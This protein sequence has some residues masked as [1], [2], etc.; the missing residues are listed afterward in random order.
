M[1][2]DWQVR[3]QV[4]VASTGAFFPPGTPR[5]EIETAKRDL[6]EAGMVVEERNE[7]PDGQPDPAWVHVTGERPA[8]SSSGAWAPSRLVHRLAEVADAIAAT[9]ADSPRVR[10]ETPLPPEVL[11]AWPSKMVTLIHQNRAAF[12]LMIKRAWDAR[13]RAAGLR[14]A[15][16]VPTPE[17]ARMARS[18]AT[19]LE[20]A[21]AARAANDRFPP[22]DVSEPAQAAQTALNNARI[23][24]MDALRALTDGL[25]FGATARA[26]AAAQAG[27]AVLASADKLG[28]WAVYWKAWSDVRRRWDEANGDGIKAAEEVGLETVATEAP[29][30]SKRPE[31]TYGARAVRRHEA[32]LLKDLARVRARLRDSK[33][34]L[35]ER[36]AL[37]RMIKT[38]EEDLRQARFRQFADADELDAHHRRIAGRLQEIDR[39]LVHTGAARLD[40][41]GADIKIVPVAA[42]GF[43]W[44]SVMGGERRRHPSRSNGT[45]GDA[46][47]AAL[48]QVGTWLHEVAGT[49]DQ[50]QRAEGA[51]DE[52]EAGRLLAEFVADPRVLATPAGQYPA[53]MHPAVRIL[54]DAR[55]DLSFEGVVRAAIA[56]ARAV[57]RIPPLADDVER[58][59]L[60][61]T[62]AYEKLGMREWAEAALHAVRHDAGESLD[63]EAAARADVAL[64]GVGW[65]SGSGRIS[66]TAEMKLRGMKRAAWCRLIAEVAEHNT[67]PGTVPA[68]LQQQLDPAPVGK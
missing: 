9:L 53:V 55:R 3:G 8:P 59:L 23:E 40:E 7:A 54:H 1:P 38:L 26:T 35:D 20:R 41:L 27:D 24:A 14:A 30:S 44:E 47:G 64:Y 22:T 67:V 10:Q 37:Q 61:A 52:E 25:P 28:R 63:A 36:V 49:S 46:R 33:G 31:G 2:G 5:D 11:N 68:F 21:A 60:Q 66:G 17:Q 19:L 34:S 65:A 51:K 29:V 39:D 4:V 18:V 15:S 16:H 48:K 6:V 32:A 62:K 56:W 43:T 57:G 45:P 58:F 12:D 42:G 50:R 13:A